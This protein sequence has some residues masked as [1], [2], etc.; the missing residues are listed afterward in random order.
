VP[1]EG[2]VRCGPHV[3]RTPS[4]ESTRVEPKWMDSAGSH[5]RAIVRVYQAFRKHN[6]IEANH[7]SDQ[8]RR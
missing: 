8:R 3:S 7:Q 6:E 5:Y 1:L 2:P 4:D